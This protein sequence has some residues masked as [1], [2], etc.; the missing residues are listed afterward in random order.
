MALKPRGGGAVGWGRW[1]A[2]TS[3]LG[4]ALYQNS[5]DNR[6]DDIGKQKGLSMKT[7]IMAYD[8][9]CKHMVQHNQSGQMCCR[10]FLHL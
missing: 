9:V 4:M 7:G 8:R 1:P 3:E 2:R 5:S 10:A 6:F